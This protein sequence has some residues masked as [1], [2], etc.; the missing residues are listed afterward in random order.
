MK[1]VTLSLEAHHTRP[2]PHYVLTTS[3]QN[4]R[5]QY[6]GV[7]RSGNVVLTQYGPGRTWRSLGERDGRGRSLN[8]LKTNVVRTWWK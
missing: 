4:G 6:E 1:A 3:W 2:R 7:E 8:M 5:T